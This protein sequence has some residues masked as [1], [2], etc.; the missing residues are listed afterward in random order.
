MNDFAEYIHWKLDGVSLGATAESWQANATY[1][2]LCLRAQ[3]FATRNY[4]HRSD[5]E[6]QQ[7]IVD[8]SAD[9]GAVD[10]GR[11]RKNTT[12]LSISRFHCWR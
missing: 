7:A 3:A 5:V 2:P 4:Y 8:G 12:W 9:T 10:I 11:K 1:L 6:S